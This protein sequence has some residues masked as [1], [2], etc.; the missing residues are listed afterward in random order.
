MTD[1]A[2]RQRALS[3]HVA[4]AAAR[5]RRNLTDVRADLYLL[6]GLM[7]LAELQGV[8]GPSIDT[9]AIARELD[10]VKAIV[11]GIT[12]A[13]SEE[14]GLLQRFV[15]RKCSLNCGGTVANVERGRGSQIVLVCTNGHRAL[16]NPQEEDTD[17]AHR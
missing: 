2:A 10:D 13:A 15:G 1:N 11:L 6:A 3:A 17:N 12:D 8:D 7:S 4:E 9:A 5:A 16:F 14:A